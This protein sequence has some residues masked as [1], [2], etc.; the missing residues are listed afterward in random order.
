M[1]RAGRP[2]P[3]AHHGSAVVEDMEGDVTEPADVDRATE[4]I[5]VIFPRAAQT[6][7]YVAEADPRADVEANVLPMLHILEACRKRRACPAV[8]FAGTAT[9]VGLPARLPVDES[10]PDHPCT[11]YEIGRASC[12]ERVWS[13]V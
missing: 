8:F 11:V 6:S 5:D 1:F 12:R 7:V 4:G 10:F 3:G 13:V 9:Q 2:P